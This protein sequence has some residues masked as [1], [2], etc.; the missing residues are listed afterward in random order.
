MTRRRAAVR[1]DD[2]AG[3]TKDLGSSVIY[4]SMTTT[5]RSSGLVNAPT[6]SFS[7]SPMSSCGRGE[8]PTLLAYTEDPTPPVRTEEPKTLVDD[9][10]RAD[11]SNNEG[12]PTW[13]EDVGTDVFDREGSLTWTEGVGTD[14]DGL[15]TRR[16]SDTEVADGMF[17]LN[18]EDPGLPLD[19]LSSSSTSL[20]E[21]SAASSEEVWYLRGDRGHWTS[22]W[23]LS[24]VRGRSE[25]LKHTV[26]NSSGM[27]LIARFPSKYDY[28]EDHFFFVEIS[29]RTVEVDYIDLVKMRWERRVKPSLPEVS[30]EFVTAMHTDLSSGNGNY[31]RSFSR[32]R[33]E[34]ALS[35]EIFP[36]KILGRGQARVSFR[37]QAALKVAVKAK[38]SSGTNTP[39]AVAPMTSTPMAPSVL[40]R[41]SRPLAPKTLLPP[42]SAGE[43]AEFC[44]L[45][46]DRAQISSGKGNQRLDQR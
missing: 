18:D 37:E 10:S 35:A 43:L 19:P 11:V 15:G 25:E 46:S 24:V 31:R 41:S 36:G 20:R 9:A 26:T 13:I 33:I 12:D 44:R 23:Y 14:V 7:K 28:F 45:S 32:K 42:P 39:R 30:K 27:A 22:P 4:A 38:G 17:P 21:V 40:V 8:D 16:D 6:P 3:R 2:S 29:E 34:R 5:P 1:A